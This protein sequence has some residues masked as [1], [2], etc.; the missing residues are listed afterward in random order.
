MDLKELDLHITN[1]CALRCRHCVFSSGEK[2]LPEMSFE[3]ISQLIDDFS[4]ITARK[5]TINLFGGEAL[6]REDIF[7]I[8]DKAK[9]EGLSVGVT[10]NCHVP[11][12]LI[13]K[14]FKK[15]I[16][17]LTS[18]LDGA[19]SGTHDWLR[20]IDG[21][22]DEV[23]RTLKKSVAKNIYTTVNSVLHKDNVNQVIPILELCRTI[24]INGLA[25]Y[26]LTPTGRGMDISD[27]IIN[28]RKWMDTKNIVL[29]W[30]KRNPPDFSVC[31]EEAYELIDNSDS[32]PWRCEKEHKETIFIRCDGEVYS[33][34]LLDGAPCS[35]GNINREKLGKILTR[36]KEKAF[37][38]SNGCPALVFHKYQDLS[39]A[40]PREHS[41][42]IKLGCPYNY[43]ILNEK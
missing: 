36:R 15:R 16:D 14:L 7:D 6:L 38:R 8:I 42:D 28:S 27:R 12:D 21:N 18:D 43:Q 9:K 40:D 19:N 31:W 32:A 24:G 2:L 11:K 4:V 23:I 3:K 10:T 41:D 30:M 37:S 25:F 33:C 26:Y 22:F 35:L 17:R 34:A 39:A 13:E 1:R 29:D 20:N 5:G